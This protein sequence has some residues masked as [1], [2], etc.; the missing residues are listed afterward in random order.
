MR[1]KLSDDTNPWAITF[2]P[3][4]QE[5]V[6][7][8]RAEAFNAQIERKPQKLFFCLRRQLFFLK[9][10]IKFHKDTKMSKHQQRTVQQ[11][12]SAVHAF[13]NFGR[14]RVWAFSCQSPVF[15]GLGAGRQPPPLTAKPLPLQQWDF[16]SRW[17]L[18]KISWEEVRKYWWMFKLD[19]SDKPLNLNTR[20]SLKDSQSYWKE[21]Q[22]SPSDLEVNRGSEWLMENGWK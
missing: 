1:R 18:H 16:T 13:E 15:T 19:E 20:G 6:Q 8:L 11:G 4:R 10:L 12:K 7:E 5:E 9:E 21:N 17:A 14:G 3:T 2:I 22:R